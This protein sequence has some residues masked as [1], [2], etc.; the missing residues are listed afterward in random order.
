MR[1]MEASVFL[2]ADVVVRAGQAI[3]AWVERKVDVWFADD[4]DDSDF[5][6][7]LDR[8]SERLAIIVCVLAVVYIII[9]ALGRIAGLW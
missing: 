9:P 4:A 5:L 6:E 8:W 3:Q 2:A 7:Y 1:F